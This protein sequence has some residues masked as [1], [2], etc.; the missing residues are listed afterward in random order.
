MILCFGTL[1][2][3]LKI[4]KTTG[5]EDMLIGRLIKCITPESPYIRYDSLKDKEKLVSEKSWDTFEA[6]PTSINKIIRCAKNY[7]KHMDDLPFEEIV[8]NIRKHFV[9]YI[10]SDGISRIIFALLEII[11]QDETLSAN[12]KELF[13]ECFGMP[14]YELFIK[15]FIDFPDFI[16][17]CLIYTVPADAL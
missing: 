5:R 11:R 12:R 14:K 6:I 7:V 4:Y 17:R 2:S 16:A 15:E 10:Y 9:P 8:N 3:V 1:A 13:N